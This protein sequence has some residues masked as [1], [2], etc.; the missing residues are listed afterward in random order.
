MRTLLNQ[1]GFIW[2]SF[3]AGCLPYEIVVCVIKVNDLAV[4]R[5]LASCQNSGYHF[6]SSYRKKESWL[7][8]VD[9]TVGSDGS[10][11]SDSLIDACRLAER[12]LARR[13]C[14]MWTTLP[15]DIRQKDTVIVYKREIL[16]LLLASGGVQ[17]GLRSLWKCQSHCPSCEWAG[18]LWRQGSRS[19]RCISPLCPAQI[20]GR[21]D[22]FCQPGCHERT[23][24]GPAVIREALCSKSESKDVAGIYRVKVKIC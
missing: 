4:Q 13:P 11:D 23:G 19:S 8:S 2:R 14:T 9:W 22:S 5:S 18:T 15:K 1:F 20:K 17:A 3:E 24:L 7:L 12:Q 10:C 6:I 21:A 16:F